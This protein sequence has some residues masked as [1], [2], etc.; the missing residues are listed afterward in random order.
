MS[1]PDWY[2]VKNGEVGGRSRFLFFIEQYK[3]PLETATGAS[4]SVGHP[5]M[6]NY[7]YKN[8]QYF[9]GKRM[10]EVFKVWQK[11]IKEV[12]RYLRSQDHEGWLLK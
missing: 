4:I 10:E 7:Q 12:E 9:E 2:S 11:F 8:S 3:V 5:M 1:K 6:I